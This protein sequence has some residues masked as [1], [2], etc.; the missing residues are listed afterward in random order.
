M[1]YVPL[2]HLPDVDDLVL[3]ILE[4][5][6]VTCGANLPPDL[7]DRLPY[8][9]A[10][11]FGGSA[12]HP[13]FLDRATITVDAYA[14]TRRAAADLA[15]TCRVLLYAAWR[16]QTTHGGASVAHY[17]EVTAPAELRTDGQLERLHRYQA[18]YSLHIRP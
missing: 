13:Q 9:S 15:E 3:A 16:S 6:D 5:G 10:R 1:V 18:A 2:R 12:V 14:A 11:R 17:S 8:V 7:V 4:S